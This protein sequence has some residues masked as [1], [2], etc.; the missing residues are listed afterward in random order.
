KSMPIIVFLLMVDT[1]L[2]VEFLK[3]HSGTLM[4]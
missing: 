3:P 2:N 4:P 1:S